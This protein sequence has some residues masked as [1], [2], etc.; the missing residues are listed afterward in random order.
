MGTV[1]LIVAGSCIGLMLLLSLLKL[2]FTGVKE[3]LAAEVEKRFAGQQVLYREIGANF[4]GQKSKGMGQ[5]RGNGALV[6]TPDELYFLLFLP[7]HEIV[8]PLARVR[9]VSLVKSHLGRTVFQPLLRVDYETAEGE[10]SIAWASRDPHAWKD[11][12]E[13]RRQ[14]PDDAAASGATAPDD[15]AAAV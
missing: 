4:F 10:D 13:A 5:I 6:L 15:S 14:N 3:R 7:R 1:L 8:I 2:V 11:A 12:I 9:G